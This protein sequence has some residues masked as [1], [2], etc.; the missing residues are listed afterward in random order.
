MSAVS[1]SPPGWYPDPAGAYPSR[2]WDGTA[3]S[4]H[5]LDERGQALT[6]AR[7]VSQRPAP[8]SSSVPSHSV[9]PLA[10]LP[11]GWYPDP[12]AAYPQRWWDGDAWS[13][14][15]RDEKGQ[16]LASRQE[17]SEYGPPPDTS[18]RSDA[19]PP[20]TPHP[21][22]HV[23]SH[24]RSA[25]EIELERE[26]AQLRQAGSS[27]PGWKAHLTS[28]RIRVIATLLVGLTVGLVVYMLLDRGFTA[29]GTLTLSS[30][31]GSGISGGTSCSGTA[32][33]DDI[34]EG[35]QVVI[36]DET[37]TTVGVG[38]LEAA[39]SLGTTTCVFSFTVN[40]VEAG[41][42]FYEVEVSRRGGI[43]FSQEE[44]EQGVGLTL[45]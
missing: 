19:R 33:Y 9:A 24:D 27:K 5:V 28:K 36:R 40:G 18:S 25:R 42:D 29:T 14:Q 1:S 45:G 32:G 15:V 34:R 17:K 13:Q 35:T 44:L 10:A 8:G 7:T 26:L 4:Q 30:A 21:K 41:A 12:T 16:I 3:W 2:W 23:P 6:D 31:D 37:G 38:Q 43:T 39:R 22:N 20:L 11:Q